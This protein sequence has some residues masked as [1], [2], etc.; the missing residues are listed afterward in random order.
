M[1]I[2]HIELATLVISQGGYYRN[3]GNATIFAF[4]A[5][6][7]FGAAGCMHVLKRWGKQPYQNGHKL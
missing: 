3:I 1:V 4:A 2:S 6:G 5:L 7:L